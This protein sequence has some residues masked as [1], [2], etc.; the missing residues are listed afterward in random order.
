MTEDGTKVSDGEIMDQ[1]V[2]ILEEENPAYGYHK[3]TGRLRRRNHLLINKKKGA[4]TVL[5]TVLGTLPACGLTN[6]ASLEDRTFNRVRRIDR[7]E[8]GF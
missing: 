1:I 5:S 2:E 3:L 6:W 7:S 8:S 4:S